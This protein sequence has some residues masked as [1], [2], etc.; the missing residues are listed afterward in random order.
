MIFPHGCTPSSD[1]SGKGTYDPSLLGRDIP[2]VQELQEEGPKIQHEFDRSPPCRGKSTPGINPKSDAIGSYGHFAGLYPAVQGKAPEGWDN[3]SGGERGVGDFSTSRARR[4]TSAPGR[5]P[6]AKDKVFETRFYVQNGKKIY[7][8][9]PLYKSYGDYRL[10]TGGS[11]YDYLKATGEVK[12]SVSKTSFKNAG[13]KP[14][15]PVRPKTPRYSPAVLNAI[16]RLNEENAMQARGIRALQADQAADHFGLER[17]R[18]EVRRRNKEISD[19]RTR[20]NQ[21]RRDIT[22]ARRTI[23]RSWW[24]FHVAPVLTVVRLICASGDI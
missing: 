9:K 4:A 21:T 2:F 12:P 20:L 1:A 7:F 13:R 6:K 17:L 10:A 3:P 14:S 16:D 22:S 11:R 8:K 5:R 24:L 18:A 19:T 15:K 23:Q